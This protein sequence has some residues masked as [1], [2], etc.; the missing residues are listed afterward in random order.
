MLVN[1]VSLVLADANKLLRV[2]CTSGPTLVRKI[3]RFLSATTQLA[4]LLPSPVVSTM[5]LAVKNISILSTYALNVLRLALHCY[6][7]TDANQKL[8]SICSKWVK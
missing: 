3:A 4:R 5:L 8:H 1:G 6:G 7:N 2:E